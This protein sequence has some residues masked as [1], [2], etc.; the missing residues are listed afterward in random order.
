[1]KFTNK[2]HELFHEMWENGIRFI[3][4][5]EENSIIHARYTI[6]DFGRIEGYTVKGLKNLA[7]SGNLNLEGEEKLSPDEVEML[8]NFLAFYRSVSTTKKAPLK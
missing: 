3:P 1:M 2:H 4:E 8:C 5:E 6:D 7:K